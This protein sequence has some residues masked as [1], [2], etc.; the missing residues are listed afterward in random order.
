MRV[1]LKGGYTMQLGPNYSPKEKYFI[2]TIGHYLDALVAGELAPIHPTQVHFIQACRGAKAP[3]DEVES[4][5][6]KFNREFPHRG[7]LEQFRFR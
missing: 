7:Q 3:I 2:A 1:M 4:A 6:M 5:W